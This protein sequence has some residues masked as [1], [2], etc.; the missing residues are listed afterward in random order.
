MGNKRYW[1]RERRQTGGR[2][3]HCGCRGGRDRRIRLGAT[4]WDDGDGSRDRGKGGG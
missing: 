3:T 2:R 4:G 1:D